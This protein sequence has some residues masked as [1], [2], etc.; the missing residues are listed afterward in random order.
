VRVLC[1]LLIIYPLVAQER[2]PVRVVQ[3]RLIEWDANGAL[4]IATRGLSLCGC[5]YDDETRITDAEGLIFP[6]DV[7]VG[8][9]VEAVL[10]G[11]GD[12]CRA[13]SIYIRSQ[14]LGVLDEEVY[15]SYR[16]AL[17]RQRHLLDDIRPRGNLTFAGLVLEHGA[18]SLRLKTQSGGR[19]ELRLRYDTQYTDQGRPSDS[20]MLEV[21]ATVF[22]RGGRGIDGR[23]EAYQV[24]RGEIL[25]PR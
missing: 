3:G 6:S 12:S 1:V 23:L 11:R 22:I 4:R 24:V 16:E 18:D 14:N 2:L 7:R 5:Q 9:R 19:R 17:A 8:A 25:M 21:N 10:D 20:S 15:E 13:I